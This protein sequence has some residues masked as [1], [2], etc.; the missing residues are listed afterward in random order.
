[1]E[2]IV[3]EAHFANT[4]SLR[5]F[6]AWDDQLTLKVGQD[7]VPPFQLEALHMGS[8]HLGPRYPMWVR[9][10]KSLSSL[11]LSNTSLADVPPDWIFHFSSELQCLDLSQNQMHG[12][13]PNLMNIGMQDYSE[14][15][16]SQNHLEGPLPLVS[17]KVNKLDLSDNL[18]SGSIS[19][20]LCCSPSEPMNMVVLYLAKNQLSGN[21]PN[22]WSKWNNIQ[23]LY[24]NDNSFGGGIPSSFSLFI[25]LQSLYLR[26]NN[27]Y[28]ILSLSSLQN[29]IN[30]VTL[31]FSR[32]KFERNIPTWLGTSPS[33]LRFLI[34]GFNDFHGH[35]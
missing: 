5:Y 26:S 16:L 10:Q 12:R 34:A 1:M 8:C 4:T 13:I 35:T 22:C 19:Q 2:G 29:C 31:D 17:S 32:N 20:F 23:A 21:L 28:G 9:S 18:L 15:N 3:L 7:W 24:L 6:S 11:V 27:L 30:L 25:F 33:K 14:I